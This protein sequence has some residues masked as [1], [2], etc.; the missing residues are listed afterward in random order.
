MSM[1][2]END[3]IA[4]AKANP[5]VRTGMLVE[6]WNVDIPNVPTY[7]GIGRVRKMTWDCFYMSHLV[8]VDYFYKGKVEKY[9]VL[10]GVCKPY[11]GRNLN[12]VSNR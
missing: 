2:Y 12:V 10:E 4:Y 3:T 11:V 7:C 9:T 1:Q 6:L 8:D 5:K